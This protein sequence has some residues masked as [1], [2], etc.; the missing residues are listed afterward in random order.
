LRRRQLDHPGVAFI[1]HPNP[2]PWMTPGIMQSI[3]GSSTVDFMTVPEIASCPTIPTI[4]PSMA[5]S[6]DTS[7]SGSPVEREGDSPVDQG[8]DP[9]DQE[10]D[11][12]EVSED[13]DSSMESSVRVLEHYRGPGQEHLPRIVRYWSGLPRGSR[14]RGEGLFLMQVREK[15]HPRNQGAEDCTE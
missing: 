15:Y 8:R 12:L 1:H 3:Y 10:R 9:L 6:S 4:Y 14:P 2:Y 5:S 7:G 13:T 11:P